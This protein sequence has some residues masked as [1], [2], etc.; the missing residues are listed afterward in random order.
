M[1][2][3]ISCIQ[4]CVPLN[5]TFSPTI[6]GALNPVCILYIY[7]LFISN[8]LSTGVSCFHK[9]GSVPNKMKQGWE[10]VQKYS[11]KPE[12]K[13]LNAHSPYFWQR[14][15]VYVY[16]RRWV[17]LLHVSSISSFFKLALLSHNSHVDHAHRVSAES[18]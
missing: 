11:S 17:F 12:S 18:G 5:L 6:T 4:S 3:T 13:Y 14:W 9:W 8:S 7:V 2:K 15:G 16:T 10:R 1:L